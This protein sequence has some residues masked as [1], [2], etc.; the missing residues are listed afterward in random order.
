MHKPIFTAKGAKPIGPYSPAMVADGPLVFVSGQGSTDPQT[1]TFDKNDVRAQARQV[2]ENIAVLLE[3]AGTSW[4]NVVKV[5]VFLADL[6]NFA[7]MNEVYST[8]V[9]P[10]YPARTTVQAQ[11]PGGIDIEV[12][13]IAVVPQE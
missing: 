12:D 8:Y 13:C 5:G 9:T 11:L 1:G 6:K 2:F 10:P 4:A 3:A 7:A